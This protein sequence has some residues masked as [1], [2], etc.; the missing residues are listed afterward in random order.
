M[1]K[2]NKEVTVEALRLLIENEDLRDIVLSFL[3]M[4]DIIWRDEELSFSFWTAVILGIL[5]LWFLEAERLK[6]E[7]DGND[8]YAILKDLMLERSED[9]LYFSDMIKDF[10][11][12][13]IVERKKE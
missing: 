2:N 10:F 13:R 4:Q 5:R 8:V 12:D 7:L 11:D 6:V 3:R 9:L 1:K